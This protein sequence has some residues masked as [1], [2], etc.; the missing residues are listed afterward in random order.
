VEKDFK[1]LDRVEVESIYREVSLDEKTV[2]HAIAVL[3]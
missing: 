1:R 3:G 2:K